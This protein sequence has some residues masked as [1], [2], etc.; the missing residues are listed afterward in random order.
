[1]WQLLILLGLNF[2]IHFTFGTFEPPAEVQSVLIQLDQYKKVNE[3]I[4]QIEQIKSWETV[5]VKNIS[6]RLNIYAIK[7]KGK[8]II[9]LESIEA[10]TGVKQVQFDGKVEFRRLPNDENYT[11]QWGLDAID[12][13]EAWEITTGGVTAN[14]DE[15][16]VAI[17]D[18][19]F[20][21]NHS[22]LTDNIWTNPGE[23]PNDGIDNDNNGFVDDLFGWDFSDNTGNLPIS[24]HGHSVSGIVGALG[25]NN[26][27]VTGI[28]W[29]IKLMLFKTI[30]VSAIIAAYDYVIEQ[31]RLYNETNGRQGAFI[32]ATNA[33]FGQANTFCKDQPIWGMMYDEMGKVGVL[34]GAGTVNSNLNVEFSGD[35]PTTCTSDFLITTLNINANNEKHSSSGYGQISIDLGS[36]GDRSYT[37]KPFNRYGTFGGNSAAAPH[38]TGAIALMYSI[39]CTELADAALESPQ[40]T[41]LQVRDALLEG[42]TTIPNLDQITVTG[43]LLNLR[44]SINDL[45]SICSSTTGQIAIKEVFPNPT[46]TLLQFEYETPDFFPYQVMLFNHLGQLVFEDT[47][48]PNR[49]GKKIYRN[50]FIHLDLGTYFVYLVNGEKVATSKVVIMD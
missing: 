48:E 23:I 33:S 36:P 37:I 15:I 50:E 2:F 41:A 49:F 44:N 13:P 18:D 11:Q 19:G 40:E 10:M 46:Q 24:P 31:R 7:L 5:E 27:G 43:G 9:D 22:D 30:S 21:I 6:S 8:S 29:N 17:L 1:M 16:V 42:V 45:G 39:P 26:I 34:T 28:N 4:A 38:L 32:V 14:G 35:M 20:D 3:L 47:I 12:A 25:N